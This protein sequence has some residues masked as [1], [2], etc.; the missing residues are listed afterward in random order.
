MAGVEQVSHVFLRLSFESWDFLGTHGDLFNISRVAV[1]SR[2]CEFRPS[3][4]GFPSGETIG[5][6]EREIDF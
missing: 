4:L 6:R 5:D 3:E 2:D 1:G